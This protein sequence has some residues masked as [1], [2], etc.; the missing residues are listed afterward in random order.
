MLDEKIK[1]DV[2]DQLYRDNR[3]DASEVKVEVNNGVVELSGSVP[4]Y[5]ARQAAYVTSRM[6]KGVLGVCNFL[7]VLY[8]ATV[9]LP[10]DDELATNLKSTIINSSYIE[11][12]RIDVTVD[13]GSVSLSGEVDSYWKKY[14]LE[15][16]VSDYIG[17]KEIKNKVAV[18]P[19]DKI[20]DE[21]IA[22]D[23]MN[24]VERISEENV[25]K[26]DVKVEDGKVTLSGMVPEFENYAKIYNSVLF[27]PGVIE[28]KD[29]LMVNRG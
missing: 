6:V 18:V 7:V 29:N 2:V 9:L 10:S 11:E 5:F 27:T 12:N 20:G 23:I 4:T 15:D 14:R 22:E 24:T 19:T 21:L 28:I 16:I 1:K 17:V 8:P 25:N 26:F 3:V 13:Q